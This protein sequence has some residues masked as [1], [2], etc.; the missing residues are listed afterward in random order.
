MII[1]IYCVEIFI[2]V[3]NSYNFYMIID[4]LTVFKQLCRFYY[5][6]T[7]LMLMLIQMIFIF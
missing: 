1:I 7:V 3:I 2:C 5:N 6:N 4:E